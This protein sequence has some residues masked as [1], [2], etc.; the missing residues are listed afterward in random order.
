MA[1]VLS[2]GHLLEARRAHNPK[3]AGPNPAPATNVLDCRR[4]IDQYVSLALTYVEV[5]LHYAYAESDRVF[6]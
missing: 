3:V 6:A 1:P 5:R 4:E 2:R